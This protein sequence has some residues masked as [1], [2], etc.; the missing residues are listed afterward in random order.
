ME[1]IDWLKDLKV[2]F[3]YGTTGNSAFDGD[4]YYPSLG[5]VGTGKYNGDQTFYISSVQNDGLTW[6]KQKDYKYRIE[7][8]FCLIVWISTWHTMIRKPQIC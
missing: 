1:D 2:K 4:P 7:C 5:L 3:S 6:E 8:T